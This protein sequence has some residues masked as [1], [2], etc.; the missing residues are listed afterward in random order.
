MEIKNKYSKKRYD[1]S[2]LRYDKYMHF[3]KW[4]RNKTKFIKP[5]S[6]TEEFLYGD[7][8][9]LSD[10]LSII[11]KGK[12]IEISDIFLLNYIS[13][14]KLNDLYKGIIK[15]HSENPTKGYSGQVIKLSEIKNTIFSFSA[16]CNNESWS[17]LI[18]LTPDDEELT[19]ISDYITI[20]LFEASNDFIGISF[21]LFLTNETKTFF[22]KLLSKKY[23]QSIQYTN[24]YTK[25]RVGFSHIR[26]EIKRNDEYEDNLLEIKDRFNKFFQKYLPLELDFSNQPPIS[27]NIYHT[28]YELDTDRSIF[29]SSLY[30]LE[31]YG[32]K[33]EENV[34]LCIREKNGDN[35]IKT[36]LW[37]DTSIKQ[38]GIDRS[39]NLF[40]ATDNKKTLMINDS[41]EYINFFLITLGFY[42]LEEMIIDI[43]NERDILYGL[44]PNK[45]K[46]NFK[47]YKQ[48]NYRL[49][50]YRLMFNG[51]KDYY[52][53]NGDFKKYYEHLNQRYQK[54]Y[55]Q[56]KELSEE[57]A[58]RME[59]NNS[60]SA[61]DFA[62]FSILLSLLAAGLTIYFEYRNDNSS[63]KDIQ[64]IECIN[65]ISSENKND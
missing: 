18:T 22:S 27:F 6:K 3:I 47:K 49:Q 48:F 64:E 34:S 2:D 12:Y 10:K 60:I 51:V 41:S 50:K 46:K 1:K 30:F 11:E 13:K 55:K 65:R 56:Y 42:E 7:E 28:N 20:H 31:N 36:K 23:E 32:M 58:F 38:A 54:Y 61:F 14:T 15:L 52:T 9:K 59:I 44:S 62:K 17:R 53:K 4:F 40:Y 8:S 16:S 5:F 21:H 45:A 37:Y 63:N 43:S 26:G 35:F 39:R 19:E 57:Y 25:K 33:K 24:I 29:L